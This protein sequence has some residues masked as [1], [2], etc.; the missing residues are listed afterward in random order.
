MIVRI[1]KDSFPQAEGYYSL[2]HHL[3]IVYEWLRSLYGDGKMLI[4]K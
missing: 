4:L 2:I 1:S 3:T